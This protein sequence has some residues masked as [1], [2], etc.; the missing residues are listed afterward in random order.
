MVNEGRT[1][2]EFQQNEHEHVQHSWGGMCV[3][4]QVLECVCGTT[5]E[6]GASR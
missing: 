3:C 6:R 4:M 1:I 5:D 2:Q